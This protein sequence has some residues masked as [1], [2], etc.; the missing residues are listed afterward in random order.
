MAKIFDFIVAVGPPF[1]FNIFLTFSLYP[2]HLFTI[3]LTPLLLSVLLLNTVPL[4]YSSPHTPPH[5]YILLILLG[6][7]SMKDLEPTMTTG[8]ALR[9]AST[10]R[11]MDA[12]AITM[13]R[14]FLIFSCQVLTCLFFSFLFC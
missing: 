9:A 6:K 7:S 11:D 14:C 3:L 5:S 1:I 4:L 12:E 2:S 10:V 8:Q 13:V